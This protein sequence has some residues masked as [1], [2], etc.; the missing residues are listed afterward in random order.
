MTLNNDTRISKGFVEALVD[1]RLPDDAGIVAPVIDHGFPSAESKEKPAAV[2]YSPTQ[3]YRRVP[4]I[5]GTSARLVARRAGRLSAAW[6]LQSFRRYGWGVDLDLAL[7]A[8]DAGFG[9]CVTELAYVNHFGHKTA[10]ANFGR[11][12]YEWRGRTMKRYAV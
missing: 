5:E 6:T 9:L 7:R 12:R 11:R 4:V 8:R 10:V 3:R 1:Q 2:D